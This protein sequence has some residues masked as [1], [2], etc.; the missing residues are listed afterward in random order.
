MMDAGILWICNLENTAEKGDMPRERLVKS[1]RH[2]YEERTVGITR[3]YAAKQANIRADA[4]VR[5]WYQ[6]VNVDQYIILQGGKQYRIA[7]VQHLLNDDGLRVTDITLEAINKN[8]DC[9]EAN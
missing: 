3:Y 5:I 8:Y 1:S 2:F 9:I 4:V 6:Q 7:Q